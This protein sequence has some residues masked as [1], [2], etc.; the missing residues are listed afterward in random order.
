MTLPRNIPAVSVIGEVDHPDFHDAI[1]LLRSDARD[2]DA[3]TMPEL[4]VIAQSRP[5]AICGDQLKHLQRS[6]PL[7]GVAALLGSWCEGE[8][9]TGRPLPGIHRLYWYEFP[10]WWRRQL[11]LRA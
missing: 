11:H 7:A 8:T 9:R 2:V 1:K 4:I 10:S 6:A 5:D 3:E